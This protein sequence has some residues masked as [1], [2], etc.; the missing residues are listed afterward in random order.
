MATATQPQP[1]PAAA[2][3]ALPR[4]RGRRSRRGRWPLIGLAA[5]D[6]VVLF[7]FAVFRIVG[8]ELPNFPQIWQCGGTYSGGY[9]VATSTR[10]TVAMQLAQ[11]LRT[12]GLRCE[13]VNLF[14][15][16]GEAAVQEDLHTHLHVI[17]RFVGDTFRIDA[18]WSITPSRT[19]L[20][21]IAAQ[22]RWG[23]RSR[24]R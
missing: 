7:P 10:D 13:G 14:R 18:D 16:D 6:F 17:S 21:E 12:S 1:A 3:R 9:A 11:A 5:G 19:E 4:A 2:A 23:H 8:L 22:V 15:A 24:S 20:D